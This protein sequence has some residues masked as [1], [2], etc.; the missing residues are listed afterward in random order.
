[1]SS[2]WACGKSLSG[3]LSFTAW[4]VH[5]PHI[6]FWRL[7]KMAIDRPKHYNNKTHFNIYSLIHALYFYIV[8]YWMWLNI[9]NIWIRLLFFTF[10]I[11]LSLFFWSAT[12]KT[13]KSRPHCHILW[14]IWSV[15]WSL[16]PQCTLS[17]DGNPLRPC[18]IFPETLLVTNRQRI[19]P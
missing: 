4:C 10:T 18:S 16:H 6:K 9:F 7:Y 1:M 17:S 2:F 3:V 15:Q 11:N 14:V 12:G 5:C 13:S 8:L 19:I